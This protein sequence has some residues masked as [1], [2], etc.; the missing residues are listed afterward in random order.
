MKSLY[1]FVVIGG[2]IKPIA[3]ISFGLGEIFPKNISSMTKK[4]KN[5]KKK[6]KKKKKKNSKNSKNIKL[7]QHEQKERDKYYSNLFFLSPS[8]P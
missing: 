2:R 8:F 4:K 6:K 1:G 5:K 7:F 3:C